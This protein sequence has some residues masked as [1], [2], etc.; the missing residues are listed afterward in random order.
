MESITEEQR[1]EMLQLEISKIQ[2]AKQYVERAWAEI[3]D[4]H[5]LNLYDEKRLEEIKTE[6]SNAFFTELPRL[7]S[8]RSSEAADKPSHTD[9]L[10]DCY[11][12]RDEDA[13]CEFDLDKFKAMT[14]EKREIAR[15]A[16][17]LKEPEDL[18]PDEKRVVEGEF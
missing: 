5:P 6:L 3:R 9:A 14:P 4:I 7:I 12:T 13:T 2:R 17:R 8:E 1:D 18:F 16:I 15:E 11:I 10:C